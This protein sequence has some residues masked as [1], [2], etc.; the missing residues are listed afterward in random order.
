MV[1][2]GRN[3]ASDFKDGMRIW[4]G[5]GLHYKDGCIW[6]GLGL[7][8]KDGW[9]LGKD[10]DIKDGWGFGKLLVSKMPG[11]LEGMH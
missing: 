8:F 5:L 2:I 4:K 10:L 9:R 11:D 7:G 1:T 6:K 3:L